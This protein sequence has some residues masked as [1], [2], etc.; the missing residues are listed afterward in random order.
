MSKKI[1]KF[2]QIA[3]SHHLVALN[4]SGCV[5]MHID[6]QTGP[7]NGNVTKDAYWIKMTECRR[8]P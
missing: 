7:N 4:E 1:A 6:A 3:Y 8:Q 2:V 5:W